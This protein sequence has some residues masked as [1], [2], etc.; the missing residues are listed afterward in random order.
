MF[1]IIKWAGV[2][3]LIYSG[4]K[5][6]LTGKNAIRKNWIKQ[7]GPL[8]CGSRR[9]GLTVVGLDLSW[10]TLIAIFAYASPVKRHFD[11]IDH[12]IQHATGAF[13]TRPRHKSVTHIYTSRG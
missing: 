1:G 4:V 7:R 3:Y 6:L 11:T 5:F 10:F 8:S 2:V 13:L 9:Y 12:W